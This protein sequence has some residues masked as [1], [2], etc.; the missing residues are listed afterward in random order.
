MK[1]KINKSIGAN[2]IDADCIIIPLYNDMKLSHLPPSIKKRMVDILHKLTSYGDFTGDTNQTML[3]YLKFKNS[4]RK[5]LLVGC[6]RKT[7]FDMTTLLEVTQTAF[8]EVKKLNVTRVASF[9][10]NEMILDYQCIK[11]SIITIDSVFYRFD[12]LSAKNLFNIRLKYVVFHFA[13]TAPYNIKDSLKEGIAVSKGIALSKELSNMPSNVCTPEYLEKAAISLAKQHKKLSLRVLDESEMASLGMNAFL[14]VGKGSSRPA[15]MIVFHYKAS[16]ADPVALIGKGVTF[17]TGG[18][19]IKPS[20]AM[21]EMKYDMCGGASVFGTVLACIEL[22]LQINLIAIIGCT[23]NMPGGNA[24]N[25]G[26]VVES[27]SGKTIEIL[28]TDGEGRLVLCD[29]ITYALQFKPCF[30]ID[31]ATLTGA[32]VI[33]LGHHISCLFSNDESLSETIVCAGNQAYDKT[34]ALPMTDDYQKQLKSNFAD[35]PN[36]GS[37]TSA[38]A[39]VAAC[40]LSRF[41]DD[42]KWAHLDIAGVA[43]KSG[44]EKGATG[45]PVP[46]LSQF[47]INH[48]NLSN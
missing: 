1:Y 28:N 14:S 39:I 13:G 35:I 42:T 3:L 17:D 48:N 27:M 5:I 47:L 34:W 4:P 23:E 12:K 2:T 41:V 30:L 45:R 19:S 37:D 24:S 25:P 31:I 11:Q 15:K 46:L 20:Q 40:F 43:W 26:D 10:A 22:N 18:I 44:K 7:H 8:V 16:D 29:A 38:G 36:I 32:S 21:D 33:A 6:G 9:L